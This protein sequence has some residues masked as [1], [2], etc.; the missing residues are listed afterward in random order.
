MDEKWNE[1][2]IITPFSR[3]ELKLTFVEMKQ[4]RNKAKGRRLSK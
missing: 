1:Y 2:S 3:E 4:D